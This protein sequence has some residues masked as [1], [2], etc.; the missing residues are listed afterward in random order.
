MLRLFSFLNR[1]LDFSFFPFLSSLF[2]LDLSF[3]SEIVIV[4][5]DGVIEEAIID[6]VCFFATVNWKLAV[7]E[8]QDAFWKLK[9]KLFFELRS[10][11]EIVT[12]FTKG[13]VLEKCYLIFFNLGDFLLRD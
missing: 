3:L 7:T 4:L 9:K 8:K 12:K 2:S 1:F 6:K 13:E 11:V 5:F 10:E